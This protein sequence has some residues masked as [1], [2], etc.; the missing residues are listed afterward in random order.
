MPWDAVHVCNRFVAP[1]R[2]P[3]NY[4]INSDIVIAK[5]YSL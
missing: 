4:G 3:K 5:K 2:Q 1:L